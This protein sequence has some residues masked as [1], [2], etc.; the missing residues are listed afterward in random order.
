MFKTKKKYLSEIY[1]GA[2]SISLLLIYLIIILQDIDSLTKVHITI[3]VIIFNLINRVCAS[4]FLEKSEFLDLINL[5]NSRLDNLLYCSGI[6]GKKRKNDTP[7]WDGLLEALTK[8]RDN[9][10]SDN[11]ALNKAITEINSLK[12][13]E[14]YQQLLPEELE[15]VKELYF[16][17]KRELI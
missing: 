1:A 13:V 10:D 5:V 14:N 8:L 2:I 12:D 4:F 16:K 6:T 11:Q 15:K 7:D 9:I 17:I 3:I